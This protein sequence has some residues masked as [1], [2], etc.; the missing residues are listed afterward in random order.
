VKLNFEYHVPVERM[1]ITISAV[2]GATLT[3]T[4]DNDLAEPSAPVKHGDTV[5]FDRT[6]LI[7]ID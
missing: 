1:W 4:L 3:G 2:A 5:T 6:M 7:D